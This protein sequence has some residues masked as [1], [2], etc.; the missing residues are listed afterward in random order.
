MRAII[1]SKI[2]SAGLAAVSAALLCG[3]SFV[4]LKD[5]AAQKKEWDKISEFAPQYVE[6]SINE[7]H[8]PDKAEAV[9]SKDSEKEMQEKFSK[10]TAVNDD[11]VGWI[12]IPETQI[13]YPV[14]Q[15]EDNEF[16]LHRNTSGDYLY[17]GSVFLDYRCEKDFSDS[18]SL[19][20]GHNMD[21][22]TMFADVKKFTSPE[23]FSSHKIGWL[24][25]EEDVFCVRFFA[26]CDVS[27]RS[28]VYDSEADFNEVMNEIWRNSL[29]Y[30][31]VSISPDSRILLLSTCAKAE[32]RRIILA[33]KITEE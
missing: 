27:D 15:G 5:D 33:G 32:D 6:Y 9:I 23:Y 31:D 20:Y 22:G 17:S 1:N 4:L 26:V 21:N 12:F 14:M 8:L 25:A 16:Y 28:A 10:L 2:L 3:G 19:I 18:F 30:D 24:T 29:Y 11:S 7:N 13:N